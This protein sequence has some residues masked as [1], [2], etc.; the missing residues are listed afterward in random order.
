[1]AKTKKKQEKGKKQL[2]EN[3]EF[4]FKIDK[5]YYLP[6]I[7]S[8]VLLSIVLAYY[9]IIYAF[10]INKE[11]GFPLDDPWIHLTFAKNL[12]QF[13]SFSYFKSE[14]VTAGSTSPIY[15]L[16]LAIG[17]FITNNE[18]ILSYVLGIIFLAAAVYA[19]YKLSDEMFSAENWLAI[20]AVLIF[21]LDRWMNF[22]AV[23]GMETTL[24]IFLLIICF[25]YYRKRNAVM[26]AVTVG[27]AFWARPDSAAF[28]GA[29]ILDYIVFLYFK[30]NN[31]KEYNGLPEF[32][33]PDLIKIGIITGVI[34]AAYFGMNLLL[35]GSLLP[36]T[37]DAKL[38]YYSPQFRS[39][40]EFLRDEV[41]GYFTESSYI[42]IIVPFFAAVIKIISD[43]SKR[44]YNKFL[45]PVI[46]IIALIFIY[47]FKLPYAHRF[48]RYLMPVIPFYIL[49]FVYGSRQIFE[50]IYRLLKDKKLANGLNMI[51]IAAA[52]IYS[53]ISYQDTKVTYA[54][55]THHI[56]I[57]QVAAA[58]WIRDNTPESSIIAT[59]DVGAIGFYS[60]RKIV[61]VA[62][63]INPEFIK[64]LLD[65]D[66]PV[67]MKEQM[68]N[69]KVT[70]IAFLREW[71][72]IV[73]QPALF[74][75]GDMNF[76]IMDVFQFDPVKTHI[77]SSEVKG[78]TAYAVELISQRQYQQGINLLARANS[79][80]PNSSLTAFYL[81]YSYLASG[82]AVTAEKYLKKAIDIF[83]G[84]KDAVFILNDLYTKQNRKV[85]A[86]KNTEDYLK[87]NP[88]DTTAV[89]LLN[90]TLKDTV[91]AP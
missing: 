33:R 48:G 9:Y 83:P 80:D 16:L 25:Y 84:Y 46:F 68:K 20:G 70:H 79:I 49:L 69:Q 32:S 64:K 5:K 91:T 14:M 77:L 13:G 52:I 72:R 24:F 85:D 38:T 26:F 59:H 31:P 71:Y 12:A 39:R 40:A 87:V 1:M 11:H 18:M 10:S 56:S 27:F 37:F 61:D 57:R 35:S 17:F 41:W 45:L 82:D 51:L 78:M 65:N 19:F 8:I 4:N 34:F 73:N 7:A 88:S 42:L 47:W 53:F 67:F 89:R 86:R 6:I 58:K 63:L 43:T 23:S 55:Q 90:T 44:R 50:L 21:V 29:I 54:E 74:T 30:K 3:I 66:F 28:I 15:T 62:G 76:E 2:P 36:N 81:G 22:I 75:T 60:N